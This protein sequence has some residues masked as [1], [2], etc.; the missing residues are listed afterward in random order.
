MT[1]H[2]PAKFDEPR[3]ETLQRDVA[4]LSTAYLQQIDLT[5]QLRRDRDQLVN[6][7]RQ[8]AE[9]AHDKSTGPAQPDTLWEIRNLAYGVI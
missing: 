6:T 1:T 7:L 5:V 8:I 3:L 9:L 2:T 4:E